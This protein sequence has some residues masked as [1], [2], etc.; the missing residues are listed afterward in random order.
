MER[1]AEQVAERTAGA[2]LRGLS[3]Y[4]HRLDPDHFTEDRWLRL[5]RMRVVERV[6]GAAMAADVSGG[7]SGSNGRGDRRVLW[8]VRVRGTCMEPAIPDGSLVLVDRRT[9]DPGETVAVA[10]GDDVV[11]KRLAVHK[12]VRVLVTEG[13]QMI[14]PGGESRVM[15]VVCY[16]PMRRGA[17]DVL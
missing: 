14:H 3:P 9:A 6:E 17:T 12:G 11:C 1:L 4:L 10:V 2:V 16:V 5:A 8:E 15:G 13:G 7:G